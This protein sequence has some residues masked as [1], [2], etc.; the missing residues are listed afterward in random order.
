MECPMCKCDRSCPECDGYRRGYV[1]RLRGHRQRLWV[2]Q[3]P[4]PQRVLDV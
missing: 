2:V 4:G 3:G 1:P